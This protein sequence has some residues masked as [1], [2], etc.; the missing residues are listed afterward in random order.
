MCSLAP[1]P[2]IRSSVPF[3]TATS[4]I[5]R[6]V[7]DIIVRPSSVS[8]TDSFDFTTF[9]M[10]FSSVTCPACFRAD[11]GEILY[12]RGCRQMGEKIL[13]EKPKT[14]LTLWQ[15]RMLWDG[16]VRA[17][18][19]RSYRLSCSRRALSPVQEKGGETRPLKE[20]NDTQRD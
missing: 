18:F 10:A 16:Q 19:N 12:I 5:P 3:P 15:A 7:P 11:K 17:L 9:F 6:A 1:A 8:I 14:R 2:W 4:L 13:V 20:E